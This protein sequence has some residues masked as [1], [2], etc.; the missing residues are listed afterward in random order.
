MNDIYRVYEVN[1]GVLNEI[2]FVKGKENMEAYL[3]SCCKWNKDNEIIYF[4][5]KIKIEE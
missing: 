4:S 1:H 3:N 5:E 2:A